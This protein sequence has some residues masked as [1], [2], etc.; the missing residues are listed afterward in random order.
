[1]HESRGVV[2][3]RFKGKRCG[4]LRAKSVEKKKEAHFFRSLDRC[5]SIDFGRDKTLI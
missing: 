3:V 1:M 2:A 4:F 5:E